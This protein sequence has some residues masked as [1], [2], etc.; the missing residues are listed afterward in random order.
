MRFIHKAGLSVS[1]LLLYSSLQAQFNINT[2]FAPIDY[3]VSSELF[4]AVA[5][6]STPVAV[7]LNLTDASASSL[8]AWKQWSYV[9]NYAFGKDRGALA[10]ITDL[11]SLHPFFR[12]QV[13][14]LIK[15]C[16]E[17]GITLS[18][19]ETYR[20]HAKQHE[21]KTMGKEY[22]GS[23]AGQS[24]HQYGLAVDVVPVIDSTAVWDNSALWRK[25]GTI[26]E[27]LGLRWGGRWR[28]PYDPGHFEWTGGLTSSQLAAG[29]L[30]ESPTFREHYPCIEDDVNTLRQYWKEWEI[31][32]SALTRK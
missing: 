27:K 18:I 26:G 25:I 15:R 2:L 6:G 29:A 22:T 14:T 7:P 13:V 16:K 30:P 20:S 32:Q 1:L 17:K 11:N 3:R 4:N 8:D 24:K 31:S 9:E 28:K 19:V 21:Y 5:L 10:M 12:D 23:G